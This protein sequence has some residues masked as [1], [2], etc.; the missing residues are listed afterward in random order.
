MRFVGLFV[1]VGISIFASGCATTGP[2]S[3]IP[4]HDVSRQWQVPTNEVA[5]Q[6]PDRF[7]RARG[8]TLDFV[9]LAFGC[10]Y[11]A[12]PASISRW[13]L[14]TQS[15]M[16][17]FQVIRSSKS[18]GFLIA[19][20]GV[21]GCVRQT[22]KG[23]PIFPAE[24]F[25]GSASPVGVPDEVALGWYKQISIRIAQTGRADAVFRYPNGNAVLVEYTYDKN[26]PAFIQF[27][28][29]F[30]KKGESVDEGALQFTD[31]GFSSFSI[32]ANSG[33][34]V[35]FAIDSR[36]NSPS[37]PKPVKDNLKAASTR[38]RTPDPHRIELAGLPGSHW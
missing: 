16:N 23:H 9:A 3:S 22:D 26:A 13:S 34:N 19:H 6:V 14:E 28:D 5:E 18:A 8:G 31:P 32:T 30:R 20:N 25:F 27:K 17:S 2:M 11:G 7:Q 24:A 33:R 35:K 4:L 21:A 1:L 38:A 12:S 37:T 29:S 10:I 15:T 36:A